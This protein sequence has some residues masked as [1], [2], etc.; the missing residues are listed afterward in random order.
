VK[1]RLLMCL[2]VG[3][4]LAAMLPGV[5][6]AA[7]APANSTAAKECQQNYSA[8]GFRNVGACV[9]FFAHGGQLTPVEAE[10]RLADGLYPCSGPSGCIAAVYGQGLRP[11][12]VVIVGEPAYLYGATYTVD[13]SGSVAVEGILQVGSC[14]TRAMFDLIARGV[15]AD[16]TPVASSILTVDLYGYLPACP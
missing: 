16:G 15:A 7:D 8:Y 9:S 1:K 14:T 10:V 13:S 3:S 4:L 12:S 2:A 11:G 5:T 6:A